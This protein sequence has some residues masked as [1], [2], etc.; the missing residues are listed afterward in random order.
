MR[1]GQP[2]AAIAPCGY[3]FSAS[4]TRRT[5]CT[6]PYST[7]ILRMRPLRQS[8]VTRADFTVRA[9]R[10]LVRNRVILKGYWA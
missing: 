5:K 4:S 8:T 3:H 2:L 1:D 10:D 9:G 7:L 6:L